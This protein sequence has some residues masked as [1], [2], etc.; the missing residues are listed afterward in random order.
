METDQG[1]S[2]ISIIG[3]HRSGTS[4]LAGALHKLGAD[5]GPRSSWIQPASDN[6]LGFFEYAPVVD[7]NRDLL[8]ALGGTWSSPPPLPRGWL[9]DERLGELRI[10]AQELSAEIPERMIV[11]DPRLS[12][13][14]PLWE[15]VGSVP[16]SVLCVRHPRAVADSLRARNE[17]TVDQGLLLWF[18][19]NAAAL[20]NRPDAL[21]VEYESLL[22]D[23]VPELTRIAEHL[24]PEVSTKTIEAAAHTVHRDMAHHQ[25]ADVPDSPIGEMCRRLYDLL[26][27]REALETD[28]D[29]WLWARLV[30][31]LPWAGP[32]DRD[33]ARVRR[34]V[35]ELAL[36]IDRLTTAKERSEERSRRLETELRAA[37]T[38]VDIVSISANADLLQTMR[39][40]AHE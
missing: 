33:I 30:T 11:K 23:P 5:L 32:V 28:R 1:V 40:T 18:R 15:D 38:T 6:P 22:A 25:G 39:T 10:R 19:Y 13:V 37:L 12:L 4:A 8:T 29:V 21:I 20:L 31:E 14:Q 7:L 26:R 24:D 9:D 2:V 34:E 36:E 27:S 3:M 35:D 17:F 16:A